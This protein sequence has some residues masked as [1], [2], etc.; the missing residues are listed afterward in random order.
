VSTLAP[1][2]P[3]KTEYVAY[4]STK[5]DDEVHPL[6][7]AAAA[8]QGVSVQEFISDAVNEAAAKILNRQP[9]K[10]RPVEPKGKG[11]PPAPK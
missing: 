2:M 10:R 6:A 4:V 8:L 1:P 11:R 7:R 9:V 3:K 5:I